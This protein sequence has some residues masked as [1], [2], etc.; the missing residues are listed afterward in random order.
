[1]NFRMA[2][3]KDDCI[4]ACVETLIDRDDV[5]HVFGDRP[6]E[7]SWAELR[8]WL[9]VHRLSIFIMPC[10]DHAEFMQAVNPGVP[11]MLLAQNNRGI[12]HAFICRDGQLI[13]DP[14]WYKSPIVGPCSSGSYYVC[15]IVVLS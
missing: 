13:H 9:E 6:P 10:E 1:M 5:P 7:E 15:I 3:R 2:T 8:A 4:R 12:N 11:Y 14:A